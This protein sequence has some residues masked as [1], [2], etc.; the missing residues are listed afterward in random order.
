MVT[1]FKILEISPMKNQVYVRY[2][3]KENGYEWSKTKTFKNPI[4]LL[5]DEIMPI[6]S[7]AEVLKAFEEVDIEI[8][9]KEGEKYDTEEKLK[10]AIEK[11]EG[12]IDKY[13]QYI[14]S[15]SQWAETEKDN[16]KCREMIKYI[17][18]HKEVPTALTIKGYEQLISQ[19]FGIL[20]GLKVRN[21]R[22]V[23]IHMINWIKKLGF[24]KVHNTNDTVYFQFKMPTTDYN[25]IVTMCYEIKKV[26]NEYQ[27]RFLYTI[28]HKLSVYKKLIG[29]EIW[30]RD[31]FVVHELSADDGRYYLAQF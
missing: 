29:K 25:C 31:S 23:I 19:A 27:V 21:D 15:Y 7:L 26:D 12:R 20:K 8:D 3:Y 1:D 5:T 6:E 22:N 28:D 11:L 4:H 10:E 17:K 30:E 24:K 9:V 13:S 18:E 2:E 16:K 14:D